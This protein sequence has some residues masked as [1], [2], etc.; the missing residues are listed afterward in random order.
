MVWRVWQELEL[1][2]EARV[3]W[4]AYFCRFGNGFAENFD[5]DVA[6]GGLECHRHGW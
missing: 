3:R 6:G 4:N 5:F 2:L 1:R